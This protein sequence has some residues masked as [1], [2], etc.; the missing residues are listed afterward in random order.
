MSFFDSSIRTVVGVAKSDHLVLEG[1][2]NVEMFGW[3]PHAPCVGASQVQSCGEFPNTIFLNSRMEEAD[4][5]VDNVG[6]VDD[7]VFDALP[8][9][10][11]K[12]LI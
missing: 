8:K 10:Q 9:T 1:N 5:K 11:C 12:I 6:V 7:F 3:L 2:V 4:Q